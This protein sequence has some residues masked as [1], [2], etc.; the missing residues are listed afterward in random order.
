MGGAFWIE[1]TD[2]S[3]RAISG[4][5]ELGQMFANSWQIFKPW[6]TVATGTVIF[7]AVL[8]FSLVGEGL[9]RRLSLGE[10]GR[11]TR[12]GTCPTRWERG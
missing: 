7:L 11:R 6:A 3:T 12:C 5:P 9:R 10:L 4:M 8:G 1:V 2:F